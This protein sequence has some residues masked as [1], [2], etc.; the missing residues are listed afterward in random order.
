MHVVV[1]II[2]IIINIVIAAA[3][4][5]IIVVIAAVI[6]II[7]VVFLV[8]II[9]IIFLNYSCVTH[10]GLEIEFACCRRADACRPPRALSGPFRVRPP[11]PLTVD[12]RWT[13]SVAVAAAAAVAADGGC[14]AGRVRKRVARAGVWVPRV[15]GL[16]SAHTRAPEGLNFPMAPVPTEGPAATATAVVMETPRAP[17]GR[18]HRV[19]THT[20]AVRPVRNAFAAPSSPSLTHLQPPPGAHHA[21]VCVCVYCVEDHSAFADNVPRARYIPT[22]PPPPPPAHHSGIPPVPHFHPITTPHCYQ[23]FCPHATPCLYVVPS[24]VCPRAFGRHP[25]APRGSV[26]RTS[27]PQPPPPPL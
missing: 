6:I 15:C 14:S 12:G 2:I 5:I 9:V 1:I 8:V 16:R 17:A 20:H 13:T 26:P 21:R 25:R 24:E 18:S 23:H 22:P 4:F 27:G 3:I 19:H 10:G 11:S 7:I